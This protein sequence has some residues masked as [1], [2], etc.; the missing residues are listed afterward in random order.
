MLILAGVPE[1][2]FW[3]LGDARGSQFYLA[4]VEKF[5]F[6]EEPQ[7]FGLE[8]ALE[9]V[10]SIGGPVFRVGDNP[11]LSSWPELAPRSALLPLAAA[12]NPA[13]DEG[14]WPQPIYLKPPHITPAKRS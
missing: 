12:H 6:L 7:L 13:E 8:A 10:E 14:E 11:Q 1:G 2:P 4:R 5:C 9:R 3:V